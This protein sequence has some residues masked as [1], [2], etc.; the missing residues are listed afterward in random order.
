MAG[1]AGKLD[2]KRAAALLSGLP[3]TPRLHTALQRWLDD[4]L[5]VRSM[6]RHTARAY[7]N[8][9]TAFLQFLNGHYGKPIGVSDLAAVTITDFRAWLSLR[10][11]SGAKNASRARN[12]SGLRALYKWLRQQGL[13][14]NNAIDQLK[15]PRKRR[16][17]PHPASRTQAQ[18]I[19]DSACQGG[20]AQKEDEAMWLA[21]QDEALLL[22][23]YGAGLRIGEALDLDWRDVQP[24]LAASDDGLAVLRL[25]GKGNKQRE[26]PILPRVVAAMRDHHQ[27]TPY[28]SARHVFSGVR[29]GRMNPDIARRRMKSILRNAGAPETLSPHALRH[30]FATHLLES[31]ADLRTI[32]ELL[33]HSSLAATQIYTKVSDKNM[34]EAHKVFH[35]RQ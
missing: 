32:Q 7:F 27:E 4:I 6:S 35:P 10:A 28:A 25:T 34:I 13:A 15:A 26:V 23:L 21:Q 8:D 20:G 2:D 9:V 5:Y 17:L 18:K 33:G 30:S 16:G 11:G 19:L 22:L 14:E 12:V 31:G 1:R 24:I 3:I 29:G